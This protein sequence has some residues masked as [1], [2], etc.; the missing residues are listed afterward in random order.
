MANSGGLKYDYKGV[1]VD[2]N[3]KNSLRSHER[4]P[5]KRF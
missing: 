2:K 3:F 1:S 4:V 5:Y